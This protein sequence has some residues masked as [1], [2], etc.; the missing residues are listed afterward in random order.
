MASSGKKKAKVADYLNNPNAQKK[1]LIIVAI[2]PEFNREKYA[3]VRGLVA[4]LHENY[5]IYVAKSPKDLLR[6]GHRSISLVIVSDQ[7]CPQ[8]TLLGCLRELKLKRQNDMFS[9]LFLAADPVSLIEGY[10]KVL[11]PY[12]EMD[13]YLPL[14]QFKPMLLAQRID[15]CLNGESKRRGKR[16]KVDEPIEVFHFQDGKTWPATLVDISMYGA[17]FNGEEGNV[18][19][20]KDQVRLHIPIVRSVGYS[21]GE[22]LRLSARVHRVHISGTTIA[23]GFEH[24]NS[25]QTQILA[26]ALS[27]YVNRNLKK[28]A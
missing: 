1:N 18:F 7:F 25:S 24:V 6:K 13:E 19:R 8:E 16:Y 23:V 2:E 26:K 14:S 12:H 11:L 9:V 22:F 4:K 27:Y 28:P 15:E 3:A 17:L 5:E 21:G 20:V 10:H